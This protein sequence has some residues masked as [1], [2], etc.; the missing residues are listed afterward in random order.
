MEKIAENSAPLT[1]HHRDFFWGMVLALYPLALAFPFKELLNYTPTSLYG[2][3]LLGFSVLIASSQVYGLRLLLRYM[4]SNEGTYFKK[5]SAML[6]SIA[7][8]FS[9][10]V[11]ALGI[12]GYL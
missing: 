1:S 11:Y 9:L 3:V 5:M 7:A 12:V 8:L 4:L 6:A 10:A 2:P